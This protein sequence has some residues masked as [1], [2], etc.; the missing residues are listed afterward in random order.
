[1]NIYV[2]LT[3]AFNAN[4]LN[5]VLS[6]GQAVV[7]YKLAI[8]SKD[9]DWLVREDQAAIDQVLAVLAER[10]AKYRFGA[11]F[12]L[13]W[14]RGGW[15]SHFEFREGLLRIRTDFVTRPPRIS[16]QALKAI[17]QGQ[18][19]AEVPIV[20]VKNLVELKKTNREKDYAVIGELARLLADPV[21]QLLVS[22]SARDLVEI[23][24]RHPDLVPPLISQRPALAAIIDG[25][26]AIETALDSERRKLIHAN[27]QRLK[28]YLDAAERWKSIWPIVAKE[29]DKMPLLQ[30]H[31]IMV[32]RATDFLPF[33]ISY[34]E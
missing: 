11:P 12:D 23:A 30:S 8:A 21:D 6:S 32:E 16:P 17:W 27:E 2:E 18:G 25:I 20:D 24:R 1:M 31:L 34:S 5:V 28:R 14:M 26:E 15:S 7:L 4:G 19:A 33:D 13:R 10:G 9:G 3:H 29:I 22:R